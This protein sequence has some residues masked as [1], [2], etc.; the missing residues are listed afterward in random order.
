MIDNEGNEKRRQQLLAVR[1]QCFAKMS[2]RARKTFE[3]RQ[4]LQESGP[5]P[6]VLSQD[7]GY[8]DVGQP[9]LRRALPSG[10][11]ELKEGAAN[12]DREAVLTATATNLYRKFEH[13]HEAEMELGP[14]PHLVMGKVVIAR[15]LT[16]VCGE[17]RN[18]DNTYIEAVYKGV[19]RRPG[20]D[21]AF[22]APGRKASATQS[23]EERSAEEKK[24]I[25]E[26]RQ[27]PPEAR[28]LMRIGYEAALTLSQILAPL[29]VEEAAS[30][31]EA[32]PPADAQG[33]TQVERAH[34]TVVELP[35]AAAAQDDGVGAVA[36]RDTV[37]RVLMLQV[38]HNTGGKGNSNSSHQDQGNSSDDGDPYHE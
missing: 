18:T 33:H 4:H 35:T 7:H 20:R 11:A 28:M 31:G 17:L 27:L 25:D 37:D 13:L 29:S 6:K 24:I 34:D 10:S 1:A 19:I 9:A 15:A 8:G 21:C 3:D 26:L 14:R 12:F 16:K 5:G 32:S 23:G 22:P 38:A 36:E 30:L 2:D